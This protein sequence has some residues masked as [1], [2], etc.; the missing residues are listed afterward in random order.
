MNIIQTVGEESMT[1]YKAALE[2]LQDWKFETNLQFPTLIERVAL[3]LSITKDSEIKELDGQVRFFVRRH[4]DYKS[5]RGAHGGIALM[6]NE[7]QREAAQVARV[8]AKAEAAA[9]IEA[10]IASTATIVADEVT[11]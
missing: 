2:V 5:K 7:L 1:I 8:A 6:A 4:P 9:K 11:V 3:K 10:Q